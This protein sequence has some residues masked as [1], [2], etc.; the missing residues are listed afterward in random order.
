M[1]KR[2]KIPVWAIVLIIF[3]VIML[4]IIPVITVLE[5]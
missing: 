1:N 5:Y 2:G 4:L 3:G